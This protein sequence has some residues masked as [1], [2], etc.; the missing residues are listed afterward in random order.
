LVGKHGGAYV[1]LPIIFGSADPVTLVLWTF[2]YDMIIANGAGFTV[3]GPEADH[4]C[5]S[6]RRQQ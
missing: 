4:H 5:C 6:L 1:R 2:P 3:Y